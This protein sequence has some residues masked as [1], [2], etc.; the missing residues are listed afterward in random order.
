MLKI[1]DI[2]GGEGGVVVPADRSSPL[3]V[4]QLSWAPV[5]EA[6]L[7]HVYLGTASNAVQ[8][9]ESG[10]AEYLGAIQTDYIELDQA[11]VPGEGA[12]F[13]RVDIQTEFGVMAGPVYSFD[14]GKIAIDDRRLDEVLMVGQVPATHTVAL[15]ASE[16]TAWHAVSDQPWMKVVGRGSGSGNIQITLDPSSIVPGEYTGSI[17]VFVEGRNCRSVPV[18][19]C[20]VAAK[21][22]VFDSPTDSA[23]AYAVTLGPGSCLLEI[24]TITE[25]ILRCVR[26]GDSATSLAVH[27]GP[28][29]LCSFCRTCYHGTGESKWCFGAD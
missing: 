6:E 25:Q 11:L 4:P 13:W 16:T 21:I 8:N 2:A 23:L 5:H 3:S 9:A 15:E 10:S 29:H 1:A 20:V 19:I 7:Y 24:N 12:Y 22:R 17:S 14:V 28:S 18:D 27:D 26:I